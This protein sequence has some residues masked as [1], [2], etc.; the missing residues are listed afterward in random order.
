MFAAYTNKVQ[1][2]QTL[3]SVDNWEPYLN[4]PVNR[5]GSSGMPVFRLT[6]S[7]MTQIT[8]RQEEI[9]DVVGKRHGNGRF[10][11]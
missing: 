1:K 7:I 8:S 5:A 2:I 9:K 10:R 4:W 6:S 3:Y 11:K